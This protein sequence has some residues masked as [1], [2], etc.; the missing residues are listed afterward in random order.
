MLYPLVSTA[1]A[2]ELGFTTI[3][4]AALLRASI[5]V[6]GYV[7]Q[8]ITPGTSTITARGPV[9]R[10]P[11]RP[12]T[13]VASVT[14]VVDGLALAYERS[15]ADVTVDYLGF[16]TVSYSHGM[17]SLP[18]EMVELVCQIAA[19]LG[20]QDSSSALAQGI[21]QQAAGQFS[22]GYGWDAWK[23][24]AGLTQGEKDTLDR[25]WPKLPAPISMG[26]PA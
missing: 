19:R 20:G 9:F 1:E 4:S 10:L 15:G 26:G 11:E 5:R 23:A 22:V 2:T 16:V 21:Q 3:S 13:A 7:G 17:A 18:D 14:R 12:V 24:Q 8:Q 6:R 25:Y